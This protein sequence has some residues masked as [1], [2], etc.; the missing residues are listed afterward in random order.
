MMATVND[1]YT[2]IEFVIMTNTIKDTKV[3][4]FVDSAGNCIIIN[5]SFVTR[6][7]DTFLPAIGTDGWTEPV[8]RTI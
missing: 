3:V 6:S 5:V 1:Q 7:I 4:L 8:L 2:K